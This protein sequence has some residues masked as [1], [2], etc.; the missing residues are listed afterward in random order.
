MVDE[1]DT[2]KRWWFE[3]FCEDE[4]LQEAA[5]SLEIGLR[6]IELGPQMMMSVLCDEGG[7][8]SNSSVFS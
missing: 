1:V 6:A 8:A 7:S 5:E 2:Y 4:R 3:Q